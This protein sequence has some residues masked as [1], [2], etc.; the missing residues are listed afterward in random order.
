MSCFTKYKS[1]LQESTWLLGICEN[2]YEDLKAGRIHWIDN[3][4]YKGKKWFADP[5]ILDYDDK[6]ITL[7]VEEFDY[8]IHRGRI[9][10]LF[11]DRKSWTVTDYKIVLDLDTH[12]SFPMIWREGDKVY[13]FPEN[14]HSGGWDMYHYN[15][16]EEKLEFAQHISDEKLTDA[17]IWQFDNAFYL[18]STYEPR[19]NG[20]ELTVWQSKHLKY[21]YTELQRIKF[22][23]NLARNAGMIFKYGEK[24]IRPAQESNHVYGHSISFQEV[25]FQ[26]DCFSF[27]EIYRFHSPHNVYNVGTHTYNTLANMAVIDVKGWKHPL[28]GQLIK[29]LGNILVKLGLKKVYTFQ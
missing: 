12:L 11:V 17:T 13:V 19:P 8:K 9:A 25:D 24:W 14:Y 21:G 28:V 29:D 3:G 7:L 2:G 6:R 4:E 26:N 23:E 1:Q 15:D 27:N 10:K 16:V 20:A 18:L 22:N 5:F